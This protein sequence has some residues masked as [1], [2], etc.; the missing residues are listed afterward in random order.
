M[1]ELVEELGKELKKSILLCSHLLPDV[2]KTCEHVVV[3]RAGAVQLRG[4]IAELTASAKEVVTIR[5]VGERDQL[6]SRLAALGN[7]S[8]PVEHDGL[9]LSLSSSETAIDEVFH[10]ASEAGCAVTAI[11]PV[12]SSLEEVFLTS[13]SNGQA[14]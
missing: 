7:E 2:E 4:R 13:L 3:L 14:D 8:T 10:H 5:V 12:R 11:E 6:A 9:R 1:L